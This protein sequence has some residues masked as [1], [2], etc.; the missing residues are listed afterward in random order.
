MENIIGE[1][2]DVMINK[3]DI[4]REIVKNSYKVIIEGDEFLTVEN[5]RGIVKFNEDEVV[6]KVDNGLFIMS[7]N[8]FTI[9][10]I[11]GRTLKLKGVFKGVKYEQLWYFFICKW[12]NEIKNNK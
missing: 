12:K 9:V 7:G 4:P 3:L 1:I 8:K 10:Y 2:K 6:L 5:H 11:S